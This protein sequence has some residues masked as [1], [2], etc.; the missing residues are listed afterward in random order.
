QTIA[1]FKGTTYEE[2]KPDFNHSIDWSIV[3]KLNEETRA[4]IETEK[5]TITLKFY[6]DLAPASVAN[7]VQLAESGYF[8]GK[9]FHRVVPNFVIQ[10]GCNRGDG[11]GAENFSIR[12]ELPP[13]RYERAGMIGMAS[14]GLHT[15]GTQF[16]ITHSPTLHLNGKYTIFAEVVDGMQVVHDIQI[17]DKI[18]RVVVE[19]PEII[20]NTES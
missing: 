1:F 7:F 15:E 5:G 3:D 16:F 13:I 14:A 6:N 12:S 4:T 11:Y 8:D 18:E 19:T 17:G 20:E 9:N 10:G 2:K